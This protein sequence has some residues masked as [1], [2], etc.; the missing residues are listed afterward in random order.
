MPQKGINHWSSK[1]TDQNIIDIRQ[2]RKDGF[3]IKEI[4]NKYN[5]HVT[6]AS[7][8]INRITWKHIK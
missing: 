6:T 3:R 2:M 5:I 8:I 1:L 7:N 4:A